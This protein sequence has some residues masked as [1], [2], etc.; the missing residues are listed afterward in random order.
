MSRFTITVGEATFVCA[1]GRVTSERNKPDTASGSVA[2][3]D[4]A[5]RAAD[6]S[7]P[8]YVSIDGDD[9]MHGRVI[10]AQPQEDGSVALSLRGATMMDE[11]LLPP[12][13]LQQI[14]GREVI[15]LA[16]RDAGF[17]VESINIE[18]LAEAV[19]FE[20]LWVLARCAG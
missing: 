14:D 4:L 2:A 6:W 3:N 10:E 11:G 5:A 1:G 20:P 17:E 19:A 18:G 7:G 12:M 16:A 13:V 8:A 9:L 15:Y